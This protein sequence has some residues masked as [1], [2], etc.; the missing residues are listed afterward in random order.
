MYSG[1]LMLYNVLI[2]RVPAKQRQLSR[3]VPEEAIGNIYNTTNIPPNFC[4]ENL[5]FWCLK[6]K[7]V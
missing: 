5:N 6:S 4:L 3:H 2:V 7:D 1:V